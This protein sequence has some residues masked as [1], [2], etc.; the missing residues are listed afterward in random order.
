MSTGGKLIV[1]GVVHFRLRKIRYFAVE[2]HPFLAIRKMG[3]YKKHVKVGELSP[4]PPSRPARVTVPSSQQRFPHRPDRFQSV[5]G[6]GVDFKKK[7][8]VCL[9]G[10][11]PPR[12]REAAAETSH[13]DRSKTRTAISIERRRWENRNLNRPRRRNWKLTG[14]SV[15]HFVCR[16][17][18]FHFP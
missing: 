1:S 3:F 13:N 4:P 8:G 16:L 9:G 6:L 10:L 18:R 5:E 2:P 15:S 14:Q 11:S 17:C 7:A 12:P